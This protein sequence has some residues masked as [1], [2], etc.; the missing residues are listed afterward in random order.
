MRTISLK[1]PDDLPA[2]LAKT[3]KATRVT[4]SSPVRESLEKARH[5]QPRADAVSCHYLSRDL[6][7]TLKRLPKDLAHNPKYME[8][9]GPVK[10]VTCM[11]VEWFRNTTWN[12]SIEQMFNE[13]LHRAGRK[14]Q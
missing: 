6:A 8:G 7:G 10:I 14:E 1:L 3:A 2:D 13:K 12:D 11:S 9:F 5:E 4:K